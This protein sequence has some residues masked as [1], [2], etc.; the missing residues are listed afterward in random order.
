MDKD[1]DSKRKRELKAFYVPQYVPARM[2]LALAAVVQPQIRKET[3]S[4]TSISYDDS[5]YNAIEI[6]Y[7]DPKTGDA[8][9]LHE[10]SKK[11]KPKWK[12]VSINGIQG[13]AF[14]ATEPYPYTILYWNRDGVYFKLGGV[15]MSES[16][17]IKIAGSVKRL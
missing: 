5:R 2:R 7:V 6:D 15:N 13:Y 10:S 3:S 1:R 12:A 9:V 11:M 14:T 8:M 4:G 17:L 16:E